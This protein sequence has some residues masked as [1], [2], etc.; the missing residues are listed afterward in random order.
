[1][2]YPER[3][4]TPA[5]SPPFLTLFSGNSGP[6]FRK[7]LKNF[8]ETIDSVARGRAS[9]LATF[10]ICA[11]KIRVICGYKLWRTLG[12]EVLINLANPEKM[13]LG[14][15]HPRKTRSLDFPD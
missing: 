2:H 11:R 9:S 14:T 8:P 1:M 13:A 6:K 7:K 15:A 12:N 4:A 3:R 10:S 5:W